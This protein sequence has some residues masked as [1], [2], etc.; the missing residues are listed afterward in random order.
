LMANII[1]HPTRHNVLSSSEICCGRVMMSVE[2]S[3][4]AADCNSQ[5]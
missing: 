2:L 4:Y 5:L 3:R 1:I